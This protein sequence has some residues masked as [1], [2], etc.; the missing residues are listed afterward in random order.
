MSETKTR[1]PLRISP[2]PFK[3]SFLSIPPSP[4]SPRTPLTPKLSLSYRTQKPVQST[5]AYAP[6]AV[7]APASPLSSVWSCHQCHHSY[8]LGVTR[9]CLED[10]HNFCFGTTTIKAWRKSTNLRR[11]RKHRVC[12][13]EFDYSGWKAWGRWRRGGSAQK[14]LN[15][16]QSGRTKK[17]CWNTCDYPSECR[18]GKKFGIH[19]PIETVFPTLE[20]EVDETMPTLTASLDRTSEGILKPGTCKAGEKSTFWGALIAS[21]ERKSGAERAGSPLAAVTEEEEELNQDEDGDVEMSNIEPS[22]PSPSAVD[23]LKALVS[24]KRYRRSR[25]SSSGKGYTNP[26]LSVIREEREQVR[27][28]EHEAGE[29]GFAPL[30]RVQS[31]DSGYRSCSV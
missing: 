1:S 31:R 12:A 7:E 27:L 6:A 15:Q 2:T 30:K 22:Q 14:L 17:D 16:A 24:R 3:S 21:A 19:T 23:S 9:R 20:V 11:V 28:S 13:S 5:S 18:W 25:V 8:H 29:E 26:L 10:G 4:F